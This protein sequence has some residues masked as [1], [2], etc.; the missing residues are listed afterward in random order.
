[1]PEASGKLPPDWILLLGLG[2]E[3]MDMHGGSIDD[4]PGRGRSSRYADPEI[5]WD[6]HVER[7]GTG[8][9]PQ[10]V[11]LHEEHR[12]IV[13]LAETGGIRDDGLEYRLH[14]GR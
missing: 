3:I 14:L 8:N 7:A 13:S 12:H 11:A 2:R 6:R 4:G 1:M 5:R 9:E 10:I